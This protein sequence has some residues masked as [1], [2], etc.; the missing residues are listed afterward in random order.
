[1]LSIVMLS[2]LM[3]SVVN[4][5][6]YGTMVRFGQEF[7]LNFNSILDSATSNI[8]PFATNVHHL[9]VVNHLVH[10]HLS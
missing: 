4:A 9:L 1:M 2:V 3:L 7:V 8:H 10:R 6:C 5:E